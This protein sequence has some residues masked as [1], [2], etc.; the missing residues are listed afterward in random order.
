MYNKNNEQKFTKTGFSIE[1]DL[2]YKDYLVRANILKIGNK[3]SNTYDISLEL[4]CSDVGRWDMLDEEHYSLTSENINLDT[5]N[6]IMDKFANGF[7]KQF[8]DRYEYELE[9]FDVGDDLLIVDKLNA[10]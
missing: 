10:K 3:E 5:Y 8:I 1:I 4:R 7:F 2:H 9:C 6:F